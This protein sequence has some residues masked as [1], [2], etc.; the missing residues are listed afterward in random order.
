M[1]F[2]AVPNAHTHVLAGTIHALAVTGAKRSGLLPQVPTFLE[3]GLAG[4]DVPLR[5]GLAAPAGTPR[6]IIEKLN[7]ALNA[8]LAGEEVRRRLAIEGAE[9]QPTT[10]EQ[11]AAIIDREVTM[12][13]ELVKAAGIK[14]E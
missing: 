6:P 13:T 9:P 1:L 11:Y 5:Y 8:A 2:S 12:W 7:R 4:F 10:P 3:A 14:G